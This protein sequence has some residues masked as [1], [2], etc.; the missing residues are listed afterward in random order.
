MKPFNQT[1]F[2]K[3]LHK[4][5]DVVPEVLDVGA[6][7]VKG[8]ISGAIK[9]CGDL[10]RKKAETDE[11]AQELLLEFEKS[12]RD[13]ELEVFK[14]TVEDRKDARALYVQNNSLQKIF[15]ITFLI[16]YVVLTGVMLFGSYASVV[17]NVKFENYHVAFLTGLFTQMS[18]KLNT[19]VDFLFGGSLHKE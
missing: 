17:E 2:G 6:H 12:K 19:I 1:K 4:A 13:F 9:E 5:K 3:F 16:G 15:A 7:I 10:L 11:K 14:I 8:D 18:T